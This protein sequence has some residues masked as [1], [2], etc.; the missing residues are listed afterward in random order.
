MLFLELFNTTTFQAGFARVMLRK[1]A[2]AI[3]VTL[4]YLLLSIGIQI[5]TLTIK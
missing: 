5:W 3:I 1:F 4:I 2:A